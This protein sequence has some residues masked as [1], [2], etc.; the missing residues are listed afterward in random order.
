MNFICG[1]RSRRLFLSAV[2]IR[3][4]V[5]VRV[6]WARFHQHFANKYARNPEIS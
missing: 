5:R 6:N 3:K 1:A 4:G 2:V